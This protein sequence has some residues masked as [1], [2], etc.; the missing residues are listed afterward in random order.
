M[1]KE[2]LDQFIQKVTDDE[3][4][5]ARVGEEIDVE[6]LIALGAEHGCEFNAEELQESAELSDEELDG[7]AGGLAVQS[8]SGDFRIVRKKTPNSISRPDLGWPA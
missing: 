3:Q 2:N 1:S 7:V 6:S 8:A 4:L 5:Q